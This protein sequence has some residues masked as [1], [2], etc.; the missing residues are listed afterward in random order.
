MNEKYLRKLVLLT[1]AT[2]TP[3][4]EAAIEHLCL[5]TTQKLAAEKQ[6]VKQSA[7]ARLVSRLIKLDKQ[8]TE[9]SNLKANDT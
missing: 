6:Q 2:S 5:G 8:V 1:K 9:L 3:A 4:L 7:V